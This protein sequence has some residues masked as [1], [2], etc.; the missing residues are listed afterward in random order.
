MIAQVNRERWAEA[1][2]ERVVAWL[3]ASGHGTSRAMAHY[4]S[5]K[6][7]RTMKPD[8]I[9]ARCWELEQMGRIRRRGLVGCGPG[10]PAIDWEAVA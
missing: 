4:F 7:G 3:Q 10:R 1:L 5:R 6:D 9:S 8:T 2:R